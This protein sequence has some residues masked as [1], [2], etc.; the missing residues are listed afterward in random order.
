MSAKMSKLDAL[1][2]L[3][4]VAEN[5]GTMWRAASTLGASRAWDDLKRRGWVEW[6][7][8]AGRYMPSD[9]GRAALSALEEG[10]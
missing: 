8:W 1:M 10:K 3:R 5:D 4:D 7:P 9:T 6:N 2:A